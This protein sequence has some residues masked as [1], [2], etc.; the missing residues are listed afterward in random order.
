VNANRL[1]SGLDADSTPQISEDSCLNWLSRVDA[2]R[3]EM[4]ANDMVP[5]LVALWHAETK[6]KL[7]PSQKMT[8]DPTK[9]LFVDW[10]RSTSS[11]RVLETA[12]KDDQTLKT[13]TGR[14]LDDV[15]VEAFHETLNVLT[16]ELGPSDELWKWSAVHRM[17][18]QHP[19]RYLPGGM[20]KLLG[21]SLWGPL[22]GLS[23]G[24]DS[25]GRFD[26]RWTPDQPA[27]FPIRHSTASRMCVSE[28]SP[29]IFQLRWALST[30]TSGNPFSKWA[31]LFSDETF[32]K[33]KLGVSAAV[34]GSL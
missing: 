5:T 32:W 2:W 30:G 22:D 12:L 3:G 16:R 1:C 21:S 15:L 13:L 7:W 25:P 9:E 23:G 29:G 11:N 18:W 6:L 17:D 14:S 24:L 26:Y 34:S 27:D 20:G 31:R 4:A 8:Q 10:N 28:S 19:V 33:N